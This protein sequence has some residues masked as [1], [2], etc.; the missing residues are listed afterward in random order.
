VRCALK[1]TLSPA[2]GHHPPV[3]GRARATLDGGAKKV[4]RISLNA[5]GKRML[6]ARQ[7]LQARLTIT[8][9]AKSALV[10]VVTLRAK[11]V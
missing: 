2:L 11:R 1:L 7:R 10:K 8:Q 4:V 9:A 6:A 3:I 5:V